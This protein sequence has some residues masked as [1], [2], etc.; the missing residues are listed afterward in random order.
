MASSM[1]ALLMFFS[2]SRTSSASISSLFI[3]LSSKTI[4][5]NQTPGVSA[6]SARGQ[7]SSLPRSPPRS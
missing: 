4:F 5:K 1:T 2:F 3:F 6:R 7:T